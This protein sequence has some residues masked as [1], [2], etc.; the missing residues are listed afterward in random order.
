MITSEKVLEKK[1]KTE[2]EKLKGMCLKIPSTFVAGLPDRLILLPTAR[3]YF[4]ELKSKG[5]KPSKIQIYMHKK[6]LKIGFAVT[7]ID[8]EQSLITFI[9]NVKNA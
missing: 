8:S 6:F 2:I 3:A 7:I 9:N 1:L 4:V 5:A